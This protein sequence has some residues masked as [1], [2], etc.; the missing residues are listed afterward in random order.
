MNLFLTSNIGGIKKE[1]GNKMPIKFFEKNSFLENLKKDIKKFEKFVLIASDPDNYEKNDLFLQMDIEALKLSGMTFEKYL[2]LD[3]RNK[4]NISNILIDSNLIFLCGGNTLVQNNF[5]NNIN[6]KDYLKD[7]DSVIVGISSGAINAA[8][9]VY[10][11][12]ECEEDL[13]NTP[14]LDGLN[15]TKFNIEPHFVLDNLDNDYNTIIAL[16]DGSYIYQT[17][18]ECKLYGKAYSIKNGKIRKI[19]NDYEW[20]F[21]NDKL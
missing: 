21:L 17:D 4:E 20:I 7:I 15:L 6:L 11:S 5:F 2:V 18:K 14:Y 1:N 8:S 16:T 9:N 3:G 19:C 10:N 12:P 13:N